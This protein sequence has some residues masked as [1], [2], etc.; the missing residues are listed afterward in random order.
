MERIADY[1]IKTIAA[2]GISHIF[3]VTGRGIL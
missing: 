2:A 1:V 3:M